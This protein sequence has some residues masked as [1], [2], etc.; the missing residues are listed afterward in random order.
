MDPNLLPSFMR[1]FTTSKE[2]LSVRP[3]I[4]E[5]SRIIHAFEIK[6]NLS[7]KIN[8]YFDL[9]FGRSLRLFGSVMFFGNMITWLPI[10]AYVPALTFNQVTG[11]NV[12]V[13]TPVVCAICTF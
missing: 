12:H 8:Q 9:R 1:K 3:D 4:K 11:I 13:I 7:N 2:Y 10:T 5:R 6:E